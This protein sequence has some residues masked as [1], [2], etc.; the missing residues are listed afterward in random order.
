MDFAA[1]M[2][3]DREWPTEGEAEDDELEGSADEGLEPYPDPDSGADPAPGSDSQGDKSEQDQ[4]RRFGWVAL[5]ILTIGVAW[6]LTLGTILIDRSGN[7][8]AELISLFEQSQDLRKNA[9]RQ[10]PKSQKERRA[11]IEAQRQQTRTLQ[12]EAQAAR[13]SQAKGEAAARQ[14]LAGSGLAGARARQADAE[15]ALAQAQ[16]NRASTQRPS[17]D[18]QLDLQRQVVSER[19]LDLARQVVAD[20]QAAADRQ[21]TLER[22]QTELLKEI[23]SAIRGL[24]EAI[25]DLR[26]GP[27]GP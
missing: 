15:A 24:R 23:K 8:T 25:K 7:R 17:L 20:R 21:V 6:A 13:A 19:Q 18:R 4:W 2:S 27:P 16:A 11:A 26:P 1:P 22:E 5:I 3:G 10:I 12:A 9:L 14:A